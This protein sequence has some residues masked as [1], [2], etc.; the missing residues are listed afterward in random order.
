M[1]VTQALRILVATAA[2]LL[3]LAV[4]AWLAFPLW[5][6]PVVLSFLPD[7]WSAENL[8]L[9][10]PG[11]QSLDVSLAH[12]SGRLEGL[13]F[14]AEV[15]AATVAWPGPTLT[16]ANLRVRVRNQ[17]PAAD[18]VQSTGFRA[19]ALPRLVIPGP[20]P[21]VRIHQFVLE[22]SP[23]L[24]A[25]Q[26]DDL[27]LAPGSALHLTAN[28]PA[29]DAIRRPMIIEANLDPTGIEVSAVTDASPGPGLSVQYTQDNPP[30]DQPA[31][32]RLSVRGD[33]QVLDPATVS[34][35]LRQADTGEL[36]TMR[37]RVDLEAQFAGVTSLAPVAARLESE[38]LELQTS[39]VSLDLS[40][41]A[42]GRAARNE[43][44]FEV[45]R[46]SA[47]CHGQPVTL[48][49]WIRNT[50]NDAGVAGILRDGP[51]TVELASNDALEGAVSLSAPT[52]AWL[53]GRLA[54][55]SH[56]EAAHTLHAEL[57]QLR[58]NQGQPVASV[59]IDRFIAPGVSMGPELATLER[60]ST[61]GR[62]EVQGNTMSYSGHADFQGVSL[63]DLALT[64]ER[65]AVTVTDLSLPAG[66]G[67]LKLLT[68]GL[69]ADGDGLPQPGLD[70]DLTGSL[71]DGA[72]L[73][74][75][76]SLLVKSEGTLPF[77]YLADLER[78]SVTV[79]LRDSRL[80]ATALAGL[81]D[82]LD[83]PLPEALVM[84]SGEI[85]IDGD[86]KLQNG[87][88][89]GS[90]QVRSPALGL[91]FG[92]S[93]IDDLSFDAGI[94]VA[95]VLS[96]AGSLQ[97]ALVQLAAGLDVNTVAGRFEASSNGDLALSGLSAFLL[98]GRIELPSLRLSDG[99][100]EDTAVDWR[101]LSLER[102]LAFVD[103]D[104]L[105]GHGTLDARAPITSGADGVAVKD[106][107]FRARDSG[108]IRY[109]GA[110][111][112]SNIGLR[113]LENFHYD[114]LEGRF[115]YA[116]NGRYR[117]GLDLLGRNPDLYDGHP[118]RLR[119][120]IDGE[121]PAMFRSLF[122]TGDFESAIIDQIT[123]GQPSTP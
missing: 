85:L 53:A 1:R 60:L 74:G 109:Q 13:H 113:A 33:V 36:R 62:L 67:A 90:L 24:P 29:N 116:G 120:N 7:G 79:R 47:R 77:E 84:T 21:R 51:V 96:A 121:L 14:D 4:V 10:R 91:A 6:R 2:T 76:G 5:A 35:L 31:N 38:G 87:L 88:P 70:L 118:I 103:V 37:G 65:L 25:L 104:G 9:R 45:P 30:Q 86:I 42:S 39:Q 114:S 66:S 98:D 28:L 119:L 22:E 48:I 81:L 61:E 99:K 49:N 73:E 43:F 26:L 93:T 58:W 55:T 78:E 59:T 23:G 16:V 3:V 8:H 72:R 54:L 112:A 41:E 122:V 27:L 105:G 100:L 89:E 106:G 123:A 110:G 34:S 97:L 82:T 46:L 15:Q 63:P 17:A 80:P 12:I 117:I 111:A 52:T 83:V 101:G 102:L 64:M 57:A 40:L 94:D 92:D 107:T 11:W 115:D 68:T 108:V 69:H 20:L 44:A 56:Q 95:E 32:A 18:P 50:L 19:L 75:Q 71:R